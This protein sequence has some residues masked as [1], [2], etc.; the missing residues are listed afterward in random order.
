M[1]GPIG[2]SNNSVQQHKKSEK[3][4]E[5]DLK[6]I[7]KQNKILYIIAKKSGSRREIKK[8]NNIRG[9]YSKKTSVSSSED[10]DSDS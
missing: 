10:W 9:G 6:A 1:G 3:K 5:K 8:I 4:W 7:K 2:G